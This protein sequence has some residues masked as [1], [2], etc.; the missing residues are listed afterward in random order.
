MPAAASDYLNS[1]RT[2]DG[3]Y[4]IED[5]V[6][7]RAEADASSGRQIEYETLKTTLLKRETGYCIAK[8]S[9][10]QKYQYESKT[11]VVRIAFMDYGH[12]VEIDALC[13]FAA[14]GLPAAY[15]C[16]KQVVTSKEADGAA[17]SGGVNQDPPAG[18]V[19]TNVWNHNGSRMR[20]VANGTARTFL[21]E[22][23]R[24]G[25]VKAGAKKGSVLFSGTRDGT[26]YSG[27]AYVF[28]A[29][30]EPQGYAVSGE[31]AGGERRITL[32]GQAPR[33]GDAC[34]VQGTK[35]DTLVF[36]LEEP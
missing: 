22:V 21:Y 29:G 8:A 30:C 36:D 24:D 7:T 26:T 17:A 9:P 18:P 3:A 1:C 6:L 20:L 2:A 16:D 32:F 4:V 28:K 34:R 31:I 10:G 14:D 27:R 25:M 33:I 5:E 12:R 13:E 15:T 11:Y 23:P 35:D 19:A